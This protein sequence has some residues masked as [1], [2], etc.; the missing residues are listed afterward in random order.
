MQ[1]FE[2]LS[3]FLSFCLLK[4]EKLYGFKFKSSLNLSTMQEAGNAP[5]QCT[6]PWKV[7]SPI[8]SFLSVDFVKPRMESFLIGSVPGLQLPTSLGT[9]QGFNDLCSQASLPEGGIRHYLLFLLSPSGSSN[10]CN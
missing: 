7:T 1:L 4:D 6:K 2:V 3:L 9:V 10:T 8:L 5:F